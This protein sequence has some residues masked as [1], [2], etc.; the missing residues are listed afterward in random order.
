MDA[1]TGAF[2][3]LREMPWYNK[4]LSLSGPL[5]FG[6]YGGLPLKILWALLDVFT[7]VVLVTGL[8]L[9]GVRRKREKQG[10]GEV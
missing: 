6:D 5:H 7:I 3:D 8:Y 9:W 2:A 1:R 10:G 4:A